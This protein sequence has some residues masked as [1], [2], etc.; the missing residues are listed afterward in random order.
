M[1][2]QQEK[3][4]S[5]LSNTA[6]FALSSMMSKLLVFLMMRYYTEILSP[7]EYSV[8]DRIITTSD[9]LM[10]F[11]M[12]STSDA[13][14]RFTLDDTKKAQTVFSSGLKT[15]FIGFFVFAILSPLMKTVYFLS[16]Y[17]FL[18]VVYVIFGIFR[19]ITT[20]F[21]R[22]LGYVT[23][24]A[25]DGLLANL[26]TIGFNI[27]LL[28]KYKMGYYGFVY[29]NIFCNILSVI[30]LFISAKL[31]RYVSFKSIDEVLRRDMLKY[32]L[33]LVP[34]TLFW[35]IT[36]VSDRYMIVHFIGEEAN[37]I[38]AVSSKLPALLT[39]ISA[40]FYQ[41]WQISAIKEKDEKFYSNV[42]QKYTLLL[43]IVSAGL[44][45]IIRPVNYI[46]FAK[47]YRSGWIYTPILIMAQV[48]ST[49]ITFL[50]TFHLVKKNTKA[51]SIP[52]LIGA[53][54]NIV[55]NYIYIPKYGPIAAACTTLASSFISFA[56]RTFAIH[57]E[58][59]NLSMKNIRL[60][61]G[62]AFLGV[63]Y[64]CLLNFAI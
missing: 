37:G 54:L 15:I 62:M 64:V 52:I 12:V 51:V 60:Y 55:L 25:V 57:R 2:L 18:I 47:S 45:L 22:S 28:S 24:F 61:I 44:L 31:W 49:L 42:Y 36:N 41:A 43:L 46:L 50:G 21:V 38:Y 7:A 29:A 63:E 59:P 17:V 19:T 26:T 53:V 40:V 9:L 6:I 34:T 39:L 16:S 48:F 5:L 35:W 11:V 23:L 3:Y 58:M 27:L 1:L 14:F 30:T 4:K 13:I 8:A 10:P 32:S 20:N 56:I 33:P